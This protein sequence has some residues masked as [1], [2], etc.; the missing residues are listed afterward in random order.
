VS[1]ESVLRDLVSQHHLTFW[2]R[3][4]AGLVCHTVSSATEE[5]GGC[6]VNKYVGQNICIPPS[7]DT[8]VFVGDEEYWFSLGECQG[9]CD[10]DAD[11][12]VR[13]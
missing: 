6:D 9:D 10:D 13:V 5:A 11:C 3:G 1:C 7:K 2:S 8:A 4:K 12:D